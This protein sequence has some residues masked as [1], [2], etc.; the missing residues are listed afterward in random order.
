M[1]PY[2]GRLEDVGLA[3]ESTRGV[4]VAA[5]LT[6]PKTNISF[7]DKANKAVSM[8]GLGNIAGFGNQAIVTQKFSEGN[9]DGEVNANSFS[10]LL[11]ALFGTET[12]TTV[13]AAQKH[14]FTLQNGNQ[15]QTLSIHASNPIAD[16]IFEGCMIDQL[17]L[18]IN[19]DDIVKYSAGFKGKK[20]QDSSFTP[21][22]ATDYKFVGRDLV[23][24]VA[25]DTSGLAAASAISLKELKLSMKAN[26]EL[27]FTLGTLEPEGGLNKQFTI[28][29]SLV[30]NHEA[31][32]WRDY[33][34]NGT[35]RAISIYLNNT[36]DA[37]GTNTPQIY[38]ELPIVDF[39]EW[40]RDRSND[41]AVTQSINFRALM[42]I[43][44]N[45]YISDAYVINNVAAH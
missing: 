28:E 36:R 44:N 18:E 45:R 27:D 30:L 22:Y 2:I 32:T 11:L 33:M 15:H 10:L 17:D 38:L 31:V 9:I 25:S 5:A 4:G 1:P 35:Y 43:S 16:R 26:A 39:F 23:F 29:G 40:E 19:T 21:S 24:K 41:D 3:K 7:D 6:L 12:V 8:E 34:L 14:S 37:I 42:D 20:G 13:L